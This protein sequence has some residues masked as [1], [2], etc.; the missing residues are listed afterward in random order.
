MDTGK[1]AIAALL[2]LGFGW[3]AASASAAPAAG[4]GAMRDAVSESSVVEQAR[5]YRRCWRDR[6]GNVRCR[7]AWRGRGYY[8]G[9]PYYRPGFRFYYGGPRFRGYGHRGRWR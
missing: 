4:T 3:L 2:S 7:R 9:A 8:Y 5:W 6:W 1:W